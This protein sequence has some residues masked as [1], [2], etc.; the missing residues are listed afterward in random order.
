MKKLLCALTLTLAMFAFA[1]PAP[2][3]DDLIGLPNPASTFC[4]SCGGTVQIVDTEAGESGYC[5][6]PNGFSIEEWSLYSLFF[7]SPQTY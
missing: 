6:F 1:A 3:D 7:G 2:A 4:A 5:I